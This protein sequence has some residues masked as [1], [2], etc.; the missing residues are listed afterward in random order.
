MSTN[1]V[2]P[3]YYN[4]QRA[5]LQF[6]FSSE[7]VKIDITGLIPSLD[8][9]ASTGSETMYGSIRIIDSVGLLEQ[10]PLRGEEQIILEIADSKTINENGGAE[11][12]VV[13]EPYRFIGFIY[14][15]DNVTTKDTND[16]S[17]YDM[18]FVSYQSFKAGTYEIIRSFKDKPAS[19]IAKTV[20]DDYYDTA[21]FVDEKKKIII[22]DTSGDI[23]C[24]IPR[25]RPE[26]A[27]EFISKRSFSALESPSCTYRF[28]ESSRGYHFV[29]DEHLFRLAEKEPERKFEFTFL[30]AIPDTLEFFETQLNNLESIENS[31]RIST[32]DDI[33]NGAYRNKVIEIDILRRETNLIDDTGQFNYFENRDKYFDVRQTR[34]L[35][36]RHTKEFIE[37]VHRKTATNGRNEDVQKTFLVVSNFDRGREDSTEEKTF[38]AETHYSDIISN[39]QSYSKHIESITVNAVGPGR[40]DITAGD[41]INLSV[42]KFILSDGDRA[43]FEPNLHLS[44]RYIVRSV[45]HRMERDEMKNYYTLVKKDWLNDASTDNEASII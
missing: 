7:K 45:N 18:H 35:T 1:F 19:E 28:F 44:G 11:S 5:I 21:T 4:L 40:M 13:E 36:D 16:A 17:M 29:T 2:N 33:Y 8:I 26:E 30:D 31:K 20:F 38:P 23:R 43:S 9:N 39:R 27:M 41:I 10:T 14:K 34:N 15:I 12:G 22:E 6:E 32:F 3:T 42:K 24:T 25:M 37:K